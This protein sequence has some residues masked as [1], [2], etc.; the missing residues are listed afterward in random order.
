MFGSNP[1]RNV[2]SKIMGICSNELNRRKHKQYSQPKQHSKKYSSKKSNNDII[3]IKETT[4]PVLSISTLNGLID[5]LWVFKDA[6]DT[7]LNFKN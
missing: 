2:K 7:F 6:C 5:N 3:K 1:A 4:G